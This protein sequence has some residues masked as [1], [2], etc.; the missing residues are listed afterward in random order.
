MEIAKKKKKKIW[1]DDCKA[2]DAS[3]IIVSLISLTRL[4]A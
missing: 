1:L 2:E 3:T 4:S